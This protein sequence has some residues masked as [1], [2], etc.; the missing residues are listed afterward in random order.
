MVC[1]F[2]IGVCE[3]L[4][5]PVQDAG[6]GRGDGGRWDGV[7][8]RGRSGALVAVGNGPPAAILA[9]E[10]AVFVELDVHAVSV[11]GQRVV[12]AQLAVPAEGRLTVRA[13]LVSVTAGTIRRLFRQQPENWTVN[14]SGSVMPHL[15]RDL[16][17]SIK[18]GKERKSE[19]IGSAILWPLW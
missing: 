11:L 1:P 9:D 5:G 19:K 12:T 7:D 10:G 15:S 6:H 13:L 2:V 16:Q 3:R 8:R 18:D 17:R 14:S 4:A